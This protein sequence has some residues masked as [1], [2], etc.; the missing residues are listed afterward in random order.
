MGLPPVSPECQKVEPGLCI[1]KKKKKINQS[2][3]DRRKKEHVQKRICSN[4]RVVGKIQ[5]QK[6]LCWQTVP[7]GVVWSLF[8]QTHLAKAHG[9]ATP[10]GGHHTG[11]SEGLP[12]PR[13]PLEKD[14]KYKGQ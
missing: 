12:V 1:Q 10:L 14:R 8:L 4:H 9:H 3:D 13:V 11:D 5:S 7:E 2:L 6:S